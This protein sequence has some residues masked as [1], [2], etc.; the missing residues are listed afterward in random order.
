MLSTASEE[1]IR[2]MSASSDP[3]SVSQ[4]ATCARSTNSGQTA[5]GRRTGGAS[6]GIEIRSESGKAGEI[7]AAAQSAQAAPRVE[8]LTCRRRPKCPAALERSPR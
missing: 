8:L 2:S 7:G 4:Y 1:P 5:L 6:S 3:G